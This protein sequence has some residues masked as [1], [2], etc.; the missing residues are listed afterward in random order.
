MTGETSFASSDLHGVGRLFTEYFPDA[1]PLIPELEGQYRA[2]P[3]GHL[4]TLTCR[5]WSHAGRVL[6]LGDAAHAIV[7]FHGQ[8]MNAA[9]EDCL[10]LDELIA[11]HGPDWSRVCTQFEHSRAANAAAIA[12]MALENYR[13]MRDDVRSAAFKL[14]AELAFELERRH[15]R[16]FIPRYAMVMFHPEISYAQAQRRGA[17]QT[18][19]LD[20]LTRDARTLADVDFDLAAALVDERL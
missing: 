16:R 4:G 2:N 8:G 9:F 10:A 13:E 3:V 11:A 20:R 7:P 19:L 17:I 18:E 6:L 12:A 1:A 15:P 14:K 5:P